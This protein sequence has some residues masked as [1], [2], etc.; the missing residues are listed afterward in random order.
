M[1]AILLTGFE[2]FRQWPV[3]SSWEAV[4][5]L[6]ERRGG[7]AAKRLP[8]DHARAAEAVRAL[9]GELRPEIVLMT[10]LAP[11]P[12]ARLERF[13]RAG[14]LSPHGG[15]PVRRG[16]W[17]WGAAQVAVASTGVPMRVSGD[18]G[19]YVCDTTYWAALGTSVPFVAFLHLPPPGPVWTPA[20]GAR[21]VE[22]VLAAVVG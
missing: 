10:G 15:P 9:I 21:V 12:V 6:A 8:V 7:L 17:P 13:G 14:L 3:N 11:D 20:R 5:H 16:R 19:R 22:A 4:S 2:P 18:A 1:P